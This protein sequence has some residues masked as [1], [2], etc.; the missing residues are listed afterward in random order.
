M[1]RRWPDGPAIDSGW[2][3]GSSG[4]ESVGLPSRSEL[5]GAYATLSGLDLSHIDWYEAL[6][7]WRM[8]VVLQQLHRRRAAGDSTDPRFDDV[9]TDV[10]RLVDAAVN[11]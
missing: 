11:S 5:T 3:T 6:S 2:R 9:S 10:A 1:D 8:V 4:I 7:H